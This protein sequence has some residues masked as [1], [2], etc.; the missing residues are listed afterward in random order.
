MSASRRASGAHRLLRPAP[1][2]AIDAGNSS[3]PRR[4][5][6]SIADDIYTAAGLRSPAAVAV[7]LAVDVAGSGASRADVT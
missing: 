5:T 3:V 4:N 7:G 2:A 6:R 1:H